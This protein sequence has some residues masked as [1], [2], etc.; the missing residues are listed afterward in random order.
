MI[1]THLRA[2]VTRFTPARTLLRRGYERRFRTARGVGALCG[3]YDSFAEAARAAPAGAALGYDN[4]AA[5]VL[6]R[7]RLDDVFPKDYPALFWL[8]EAIAGAASVFDLG[9]HVGLSYYAFRRY[10]AYPPGLRWVV[11]D[12]PAVTAVGAALAG[13]CG[14]D[15]LAFTTDPEEAAGAD[16]LF[17]AG[18]LQYIERPMSE[19]LAGMAER[20]RHVIINQMPTHP[21]REFVTLQNIGVAF[22]P[23]RVGR[24]DAVPEA[25]GRLGYELV[26]AWE[27]PSRRTGVPYRPDASP[28]AYSGYYLRLR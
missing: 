15:A 3:M 9:G 23:Y 12:V 13:E 10:L 14:A 1:R 28:V 26:D 16:V 2:A 20:P 7:D 27:D 11:C 5:A 21:G 25:L 17:A 22:C 8:R 18:S 4:T 19:L 6:Y 24:A